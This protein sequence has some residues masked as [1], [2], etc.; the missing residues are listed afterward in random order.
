M[1]I[2]L[3]KKK[4]KNLSR[5]SKAVPVNFTPNVAGGFMHIDET[6]KCHNGDGDSG[7]SC[8]LGC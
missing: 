1:K 3:N 6:D 5:D 2:K 7:W 4:F 8:R